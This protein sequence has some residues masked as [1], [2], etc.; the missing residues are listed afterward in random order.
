MKV[1]K[2][3]LFR[4]KNIRSLNNYYSVAISL[5]F[6]AK[7]LP[8]YEVLMTIVWKIVNRAICHISGAL[9][10]WFKSEKDF[11]NTEN[12]QHWKLQGSESIKKVKIVFAYNPSQNMLR[13]IYSIK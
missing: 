11:R 8:K 9:N 13:P 5:A 12:V 1:P 7:F 4:K 6:S 10:I 3:F 2:M